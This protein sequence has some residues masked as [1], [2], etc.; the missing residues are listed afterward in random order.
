L[1]LLEQ[2]RAH[3]AVDEAVGI[4]QARRACSR[5]Q[6]REDLGLRRGAAGMGAEARR[7]IAVVDASADGQADPDARW[8]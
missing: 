7:M 8:D 3:G 6:A 1:R 4:L 2:L 5:R